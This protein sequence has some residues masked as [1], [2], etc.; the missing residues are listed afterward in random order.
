MKPYAES[1][2]QN[3]API[4]AVIE[5]LLGHCRSLLEIGSGTG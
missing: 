4:L 3:R 5:P 2:D 1:C